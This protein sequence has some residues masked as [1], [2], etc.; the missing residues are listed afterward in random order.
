[1]WLMLGFLGLP[2]MFGLVARFKG[3]SSDE[4]RDYTPDYE[5]RLARQHRYEKEMQITRD[6][7]LT[8]MPDA[9]PEVEGLDV[10][11]FFI[12]SLEVGGDYFDY[13][14]FHENGVARQFNLAVVDVSGKGMQAAVT[15]IFTSGLLLSR[16]LTDQA[17]QAMS[18][19]NTILK[20]KTHP[21]TFITCLI[22]EYQLAD[23]KLTFTNAGNSKPL[24]K[25]GNNVRFLDGADPRYPL[26]VQFDVDYNPTEVILQPGD[27]LLFYSDG[28]PEARSDNGKFL[29]YEYIEKLMKWMDTSKLTAAEICDIIR[30]K[31][32]EFSNYELADDITVVVM[33]VEK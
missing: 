3:A 8:L 11:G 10:K 2:F 17:H 1:M 4:Y 18:K 24:L 30:R 13:E 25:R 33:K 9:E 22:A 14:V 21:K 12:P 20:Q 26:G 16:L 27:L 7:Q 15:A 32:L 29:D 23:R 6:S 19:V 31:I 28:L 5:E